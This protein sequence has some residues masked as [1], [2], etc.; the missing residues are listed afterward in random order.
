MSVWNRGVGSGRPLRGVWLTNA[1][2]LTLDAGSFTVI[3]AD[4]FAGQGLI[5]SV[6]PGEKRLVSYG[7]AL[8]A[9]VKGSVGDSAGHVLKI[10]ARSGV[11]R[12]SGETSTSCSRTRSTTRR[13]VAAREARRLHCRLGWLLPGSDLP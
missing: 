10:V 7:A 4:A 13:G 2:A 1:S 11:L 6:K 8:A 5:E 3:D 9:L 12:A